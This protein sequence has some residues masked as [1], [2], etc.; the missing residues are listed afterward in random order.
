MCLNKP[1][2][3]FASS[4]EELFVQDTVSLHVFTLEAGDLVTSC[5]LSMENLC[6][7]VVL[8]LVQR[9][10]FFSDRRLTPLSCWPPEILARKK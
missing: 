10:L 7:V 5:G 3:A 8:L 1:P 4:A 6:V 2:N 9:T